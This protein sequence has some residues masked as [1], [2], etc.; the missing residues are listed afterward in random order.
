MSF[1]HTSF[2]TKDQNIPVLNSNPIS[3][4]SKVFKLSTPFITEGQKEL[5]NIQVTYH[6]YGEYIPGKSKVI[7]ACHALTGNSDVFD[8]WQGLFGENAF[9][10]P[11]DFFIVCANVLGSCY[12][13]T[14][15]EHSGENGDPLL[16]NFP[17]I[18][19]RD[20]ARLHD[21][22]RN[23]IDVASVNTLIGAS[24]GGQQALEWAI[25]EPKII[26]N[27]ILIAT[28]ARHSAFG[29][30]FNES[31][32]LAIY[33]DPTYGKGEIGDAKNGLA[34]ARSIAMLSYRSY[35]GYEKTQTEQDDALTD[36][37][38]A[39][40]Y[41]RYQGDKLAKRFNAYSYVTLS[42]AMDS[43][44]VGRGRESIQKALSLVQ[45]KTLVVGIDSD[46]LF[47]IS[48]QYFLKESISSAKFAMISSDFGHDGF[49]VENTQLVNII[50]DFLYNQFKKHLPTTFKKNKK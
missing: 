7:W 39:S 9:F 47:P 26:E 4:E 28:N 24:L 13:T 2:N 29:I 18:T 12:G 27:L 1:N 17:L 37:F 42:K 32:R 19:P 44:N 46:S 20:M 14:G 16:N 3:F 10:N 40:S 35:S 45:A 25:E 50:S 8:W 33:G 41:Q 49:L 6:T 31:Q 5:K 15:P 48:E 22:L 11:K 23:H 38:K 36:G 30:A 43:H 21:L 34:I